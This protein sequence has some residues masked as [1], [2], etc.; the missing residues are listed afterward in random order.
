MSVPAQPPAWMV[1][2][3]SW[4]PSRFRGEAPRRTPYELPRDSDELIEF[5]SDC[6]AQEIKELY[7]DKAIDGIVSAALAVAALLC[8]LVLLLALSCGTD[9]YQPGRLLRRLRWENGR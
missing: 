4:T 8:S 6:A 2:T 9:R 7:E 5:M 1:V 3:W